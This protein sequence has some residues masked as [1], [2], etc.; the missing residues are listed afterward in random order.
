MPWNSFLLNLFLT[1]FCLSSFLPTADQLVHESGAVL[2]IY[3]PIFTT[4]EKSP[5][6]F[7]SDLKDV[8]EGFKCFSQLSYNDNNLGH[9]PFILRLKVSKLGHKYKFLPQNHV[10]IDL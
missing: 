9:L 1:S 7:R 6:F 3:S 10:R 8:R 2:N 5:L 4:R